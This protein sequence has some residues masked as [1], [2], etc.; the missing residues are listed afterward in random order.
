MAGDKYGLQ[1]VNDRYRGVEVVIRQILTTD[2]ALKEKTH[3]LLR[4]AEI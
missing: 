2:V 3:L 1:D 4:I